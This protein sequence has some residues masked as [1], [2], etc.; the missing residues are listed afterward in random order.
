MHSL[1]L[2]PDDMA[3]G[4]GDMLSFAEG[5]PWHYGLLD[6]LG[7]A[8]SDVGPFSP[9]EPLSGGLGRW[10]VDAI[11]S[12]MFHLSPP[13]IVDPGPLRMTNEYHDA[14]HHQ[15]AAGLSPF[16]V[17][18]PLMDPNSSCFSG[19]AAEGWTGL[20][21]AL[22]S[23]VVPTS[24]TGLIASPAYEPPM[25][26]LSPSVRPFDGAFF[27]VTEGQCRLQP[28]AVPLHEQICAEAHI[29]DH[30]DSH[31]QS[32]VASSNEAT[33]VLRKPSTKRTGN[34]GNTG[35]KPPKNMADA[36]ASKVCGFVSASECPT[37]LTCLA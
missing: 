11:P 12:P 28:I 3:F 27:I 2:P 7:I 29:F 1:K 25:Y 35:R 18:T 15:V 17:C 8:P 21:A 5:P 6:S 13:D 30:S 37:D 23:P 4:N 14:Q 24:F 33:R 31:S 10:G 20:G 22:M 26:S 32:S 16:Q 34:E 9:Y 36:R 19:D